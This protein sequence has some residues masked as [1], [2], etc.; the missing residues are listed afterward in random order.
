MLAAGPPALIVSE[1]SFS[2]FFGVTTP[3][4]GGAFGVT[5]S[6][7]LRW[8]K[9]RLTLRRIHDA[10]LR[11]ASSAR[12]SC[13]A[14]RSLLLHSRFPRARGQPLGG[15][16]VPARPAGAVGFL[17]VVNLGVFLLAFFLDFFEIA[18]IV[19]PLIAPIACAAGDDMIWLAVRF[20]QSISRRPSC[21]RHRPLQFAQRCPAID[22]NCKPLLRRRP[23]HPDPGTRGDHPDY[24]C[25]CWSFGHRS[26]LSISSRSGIDLPPPPD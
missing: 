20:S 4:E 7:V 10:A 22:H 12:A 9:G 18:L 5:A 13:S 24:R 3:S 17:V 1:V 11:S 8:A 19:L 23:L 25:R 6:L 26:T 15:I 21:I 2:I 14:A 16:D